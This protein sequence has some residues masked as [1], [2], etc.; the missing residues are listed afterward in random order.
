M[1]K[2]AKM[3][4]LLL[5][6]LQIAILEVE[7]HGYQTQATGDISKQAFIKDVKDWLN[8]DKDL[9]EYYSEVTIYNEVSDFLTE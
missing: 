2:D 4:A 6:N 1:K 8:M 9:K 5:K 3:E 7:E